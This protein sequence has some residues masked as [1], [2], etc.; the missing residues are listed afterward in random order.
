MCLLRGSMSGFGVLRSLHRECSL[1]WLVGNVGQA[2]LVRLLAENSAND[3]SR[4][5]RP[6]VPDPKATS[7]LSD[8]AAES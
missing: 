7:A 6:A 5:A 8:W 3:R 1:E 2:V 4:A